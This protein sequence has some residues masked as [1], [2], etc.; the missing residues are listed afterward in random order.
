LELGGDCEFAGLMRR[1]INRLKIIASVLIISALM[2]FGCATSNPK[3]MP[4]MAEQDQE[5][6]KFEG[7]AP[8]QWQV[9]YDLFWLGG[10][11]AAGKN[12]R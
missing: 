10:S 4:L 12:E 6:Q 11:A 5:T 8:W 1:Q 3:P 7:D 2:S 9:L